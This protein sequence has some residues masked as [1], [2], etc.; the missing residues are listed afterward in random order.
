[1]CATTPASDFDELERN[2]ARA[3]TSLVTAS[4]GP[5]IVTATPVGVSSIV[6]WAPA[7]V[8]GQWAMFPLVG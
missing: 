7:T 8:L 1:L 3:R 5:V 2:A 4:V 6:V